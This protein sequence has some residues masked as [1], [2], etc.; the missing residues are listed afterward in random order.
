MKK[1]ILTLTMTA[2]LLASL[3]ATAVAETQQPSDAAFA[4]E[5][6]YVAG[7]APAEI[8]MT[9]AM[10]PPVHALV[11]TMLENDMTYNQDSAEFLWTGLYYM[12]GIY[13]E[14]D[15]RV[16]VTD[17]A[18]I[19]PLEVA[20]DYAQPLFSGSETLPVLPEMLADRIAYQADEGVYLMARGD[21]G[22]AEI[23]LY[24]VGNSQM[25]GSL[26][27]PD[28]GEA[29]CQFTVQLTA[30]DTMFGYAIADLTIA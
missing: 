22:L 19:I 29:L 2:F 24:P 27:Y 18:L 17:D 25:A 14:M 15:E 12:L 7:S 3:G 1:L 9:Q 13:G 28:T 10:L 16:E 5:F 23:D 20:M 11:L 6:V 26:T 8:D 21:A 4:G 30:V